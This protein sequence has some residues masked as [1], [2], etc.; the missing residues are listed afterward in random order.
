MFKYVNKKDMTIVES[1][2][3][4]DLRMKEFR[5]LKLYIPD[6]ESHPKDI[7]KGY[8]M[9]DIAKE[10]GVAFDTIARNRQKLLPFPDGRVDRY[11]VWK[12]IPGNPFTRYPSG[13]MRLIPQIIDI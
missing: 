11:L 7:K 2:V 5:H 13:A 1:P 10:W 9:M 6:G 8:T 4:F 3:R 12:K